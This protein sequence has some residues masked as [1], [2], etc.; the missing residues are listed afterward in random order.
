[1]GTALDTE[2][3][4]WKTGQFQIGDAPNPISLLYEH[5]KGIATLAI[6]FLGFSVGF[7]DKLVQSANFTAAPWM[8]TSV[9]VLLILAIVLVLAA[10]ANLHIFLFLPPDVTVQKQVDRYKA[11][12]NRAA[13]EIGIA[14]WSLAGAA[15]VFAVFGA[16]VMFYTQR[17]LTLEAAIG[18]AT[19]FCDRVAGNAAAKWRA[20]TSTL[21]ETGKLQK[22]AL[23]DETSKQSCS[24]AVRIADGDIA[25][26]NRIE[27]KPAPPA[28]EAVDVTALQRWLQEHG[29]HPGPA[30]GRFGRKTAAALARF[31]LQQNLRGSGRL[32]ENT[33]KALGAYKRAP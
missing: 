22:I 13:T 5:N 1:M 14:G 28:P 3:A 7:S 6:G 4:K 8:L 9:W 15:V 10:S 26:F 33:L 25:Q 11:R 23:T 30:D 20:D 24:V 19:V 21:D 17:P 31:Q 27:P 16:L 29:Y 32:D 12:Y 2:A 18:K